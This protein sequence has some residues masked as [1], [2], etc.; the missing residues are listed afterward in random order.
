M[1]RLVRAL[2]DSREQQRLMLV[3]FLPAGW[4]DRG[5]HEACVAA[6]MD[7][8]VDALEIA[9]PSPPLPMDGPLLQQAAEVAVREVGTAGA[10]LRLAARGRG[11]RRAAIIGLFY[12]HAFDELGLQGVIDTCVESDADALLLPEHSFAEQVEI[13]RSARAAGLEQVLFLFLEKDLELLADLDLQ[14]PVIYVQSADLRTGDPFD[15]AKARE[16]V[17]ELREAL[18]GQDAAVLVGFGVRG[19]EEIGEL[20]GSS[21]DGVIVGTAL[22]AAAKDG[23]APLAD[24]VR[25]MLPALDRRPQT[26][27][28]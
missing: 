16:R 22:T 28:V 3:G 10:A 26:T 23:H 17:G 1:N 15:A 4:P 19:A 5:R 21:I 20:A 8:G 13:A 27:G 18:G 9:V 25:D 24:M 12:R 11:E 7:G 2:Q 6:V 14:S